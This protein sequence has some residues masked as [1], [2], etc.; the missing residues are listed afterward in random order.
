MQ[1]PFSLTT[2]WLDGSLEISALEQVEFL[3]KVYLRSL[4][5]SPFSYET[6]KKI[7]FVDQSAT[8]TIYAK[9]GWASRAKPQVGWYVGYL[10]TPKNV[11]FFAI[12]YSRQRA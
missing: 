3:K 6:L 7:M 8:Y 2:F 10:E 4:P 5:F 9:T 11:W 1:E 12:P